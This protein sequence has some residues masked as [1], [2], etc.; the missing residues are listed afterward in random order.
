VALLMME[1]FDAQDFAVKGWITTLG[2]VASSVAVSSTTPTGSGASLRLAASTGSGGFSTTCRK[3]FSAASQ[4]FIGFN[5]MPQAQQFA[6]S[7][8]LSLNGDNGVTNHL[9]LQYLSNNGTFGLYRGTTQIAVSSIALP[10]G[11]W[12]FIEISATISDTVGAVEVRVNGNTALTFA[13]D[14]KNA[15]TATTLDT[16]VFGCGTNNTSL[17]TTIVDDLYVLSSSGSAPLNTFLGPVRVQTLLP[18]GAGSSTQFTPVSGANYTN[19]NDV[20]DNTATYVSDTVSGHRDTYAMDDLAAGSDIIYGVQQVMHA[21]ALDVGTTTIK[22][23]QKSG[24]TV[25]YGATKTP[26]ASILA[27]LD[28]FET[29]PATSAAYTQT[30]VNALEAGVQIA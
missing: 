13:G 30:E 9:N 12:S 26:S 4:V 25:S 2:N 5:L 28:V 1:G 17:N 20:P 14:T 15:G 7:N 10:I 6:G 27:Y 24:A 16:V 22:Q 19:V 8:F 23:A 29:N 11:A 3:S 18:S 21:A